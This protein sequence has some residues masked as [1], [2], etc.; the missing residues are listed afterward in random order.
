MHFIVNNDLLAPDG[1]GC[2]RLGCLTGISKS[3][4]TVIETPTAALMT[5]GGSVVHLTADVL[6]RVF[7]EPKL[8]WVP[9]SNSIQ[10]E[11]G[12]QAQGEGVAKFAGLPGHVSCATLQNISEIT[13]NGHYELDKV[14]VWTKNGKKLLTA[15][16]YMELM[17]VF[18]PDIILAIADGR[19]SLD[20]G[21]KRISKSV[22]RTQKMLNVCMEKYKCSEVL[23]DSLILG[24]IV[25]C[26]SEKMLEKSIE[27]IF[28]YSDI[29]AG[30]AISGLSD[31]SE[32][33]FNASDKLSIIFK[34][35]SDTIPKNFLKVL[36][37][38]WKPDVVLTAIEYGWDIFDGSLPLKLTNL[39]YALRLHFDINKNNDSVYVL[40][41]NYDR[42]KDD[43]NPILD[44]CECLTCRKHTRAYIQ[45]LLKT[46]EMLSSVLLSIHNLHNF[47]QL[48]C[49][50]RRHIAA[51]TFD[52][53][54]KYI[55]EQCQKLDPFIVYKEES[56]K[57]L[58]QVDE[59]K[60]KIRTND[61]DNINSEKILNT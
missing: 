54:K 58:K 55:Q 23:A 21:S 12:L 16:R 25:G 35:I 34:K 43:F 8:L 42:Y 3:P 28:K 46:R 59:H 14:P 26:G 56:I 31:G 47:D 48:F 29:L 6:A 57:D 24:V 33:S 51:K 61:I 36:E 13:P 22:D 41:M 18:K 32:R 5:Q 38:S 2:E 30:V 11:A 60:K 27:N 7:T 20:E 50:A 9:L 52:L 4:K 1:A 17:E 39:G 15:E 10:L 37:G 40:N 44:G 19:T 49:H 53:F 45:H